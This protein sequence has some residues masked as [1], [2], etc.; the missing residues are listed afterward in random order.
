MR[1]LQKMETDDP[2]ALMGKTL[3]ATYFGATGYGAA[4]YRR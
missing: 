4:R 3:A 1:H 2:D